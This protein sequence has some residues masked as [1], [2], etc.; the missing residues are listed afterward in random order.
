MSLK[1]AVDVLWLSI[2]KILLAEEPPCSCTYAADKAMSCNLQPM[3]ITNI[4]ISAQAN[5]TT[6]L[7]S[8]AYS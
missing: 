5:N 8:A 2:L 7:P 1:T 6:S 4:C 3:D